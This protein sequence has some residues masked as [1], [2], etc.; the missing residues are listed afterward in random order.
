M[1]DV[2]FSAVFRVTNRPRVFDL[3][4]PVR[5]MQIVNKNDSALS[6]SGGGCLYAVLEHCAGAE[7]ILRPFERKMFS[8]IYVRRVILWAHIPDRA[9]VRVA[10][11]YATME[12]V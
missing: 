5:A 7:E 10:V 4:W 1:S 9:S 6:V 2:V 8:G 3:P 11:H 12:A